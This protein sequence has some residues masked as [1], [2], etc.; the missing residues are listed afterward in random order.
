MS[1][2]PH[3]DGKVALVTGGARGIGLASAARL[4]EAGAAVLLAD[5]EQETL[6]DATAGLGPDVATFVGDIT[7][8]GMPDAL[9]SAVLDRWGRVDIVFNNAGYNWDAPLVELSDQQFQA[10]LEIHLI[11][12]FRILRAVGPHFIESAARD[13][14]KGE[15]TFRKVINSSSISG[16]MGNPGQANYNAAKAGVI[17]LTK[18]LAKEWGPHRVNVN[19]VAPGFIETRLTAVANGGASIRVGEHEVALGISADHRAWGSHKCHSAGREARTRWRASSSRWPVRRRTTSRARWCP[20]Q[21]GSCSGCQVES[22]PAT[23][24]RGNGCELRYRARSGAGARRP[25]IRRGRDVPSRSRRSGGARD[26]ARKA[27]NTVHRR[28]PRP[29]SSRVR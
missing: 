21:V 20:S 15:E 5:I 3:L 24:C 10:M 16:T 8:P 17:G 19:A 18:G 28:P 6:A 4:V 1:L 27:G 14:E 29:R 26:Q 12:P 7:D 25:G 22:G 13:R 11:A 9:V 23:P 2:A